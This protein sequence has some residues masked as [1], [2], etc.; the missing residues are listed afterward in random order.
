MKNITKVD[1][2]D[3]RGYWFAYSEITAGLANGSGEEIMTVGKKQ[4]KQ[5]LNTAMSGCEEWNRDCKES[6]PENTVSK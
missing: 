1:N 4:N 3:F 5:P 2:K 6:R